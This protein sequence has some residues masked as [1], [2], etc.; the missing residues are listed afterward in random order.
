MGRII[1]GLILI[2]IGAVI[3][4]KYRKV[5]QLLG[6]SAWAEKWLGPGQSSFFYQLV[7]IVIS[8]LGMIIT[9]N[10]HWVIF[11]GFFERIFGSVS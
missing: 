5:Y 7:G 6:R 11:G 10:L 8:I 9:T 3:T 4:I 1:L 2:A